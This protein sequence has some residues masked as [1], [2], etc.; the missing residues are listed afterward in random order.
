MKDLINQ[1]KAQNQP[2]TTDV[3]IR[4]ISQI[5]STLSHLKS[6]EIIH[7]DLKPENII[8]TPEGNFKIIDFDVSQ[9]FEASTQ[10]PLSSKADT[11]NYYV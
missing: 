8:L 5:S 10:N 6:L 1:R 7:R 2:F 11:V 4:F 9:T 3:I